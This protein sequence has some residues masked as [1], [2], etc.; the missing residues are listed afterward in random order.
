[1]PTSNSAVFDLV[2]AIGL[3]VNKLPYNGSSLT[4]KQRAELVGNAERLAIA[5]REPFENLY[6]LGTMVGCFLLFPFFP[7]D[8][9]GRG[10]GGRGGRKRD[11]E[12]GGEGRGKEYINSSSDDV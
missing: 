8:S 1:M 7:L 11:Q 9:E 10:Q 12:R 3:L 5:A 2:Q 6:Y 4:N